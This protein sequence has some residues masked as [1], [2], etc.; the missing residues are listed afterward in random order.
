MLVTVHGPGHRAP[1]LERC[2]GLPQ[3]DTVDDINPALPIRG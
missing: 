2:S 3:A 1:G